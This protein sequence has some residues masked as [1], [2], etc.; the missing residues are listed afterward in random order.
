V[1]RPAAG[2]SQPRRPLP[3]N[4][5]LVVHRSDGSGTTFIWTDYLSKTSPE[6][7]TQV[8]SGTSVNWPVGLGAKGNE[9]VAG[10]VKQSQYSLGYVELIYAIQNKMAYGR[11]RNASGQFVQPDLASVTAAAAGRRRQHARRFPRLH[12]QR[13]GQGRLSDLQFHLAAHSKPDP[14]RHQE[15]DSDRFPAVD[16]GTGTED[17]EPLSYAPLP[18]RVVEAE[19]KAISAIQ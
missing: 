9:G 11:V 5:I 12:H 17:A 6:W 19:I 10:M 3:A 16:A 15:A 4:E 8:G 1:E 2:E 18:K 7:K 13:A 14:G